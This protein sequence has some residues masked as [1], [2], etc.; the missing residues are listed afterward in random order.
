M[1]IARRLGCRVL[2][3]PYVPLGCAAHCVLSTRRRDVLCPS[4]RVCKGLAEPGPRGEWS[5]E[6]KW[7]SSWGLVLLLLILVSVLLI[8]TLINIRS[9]VTVVS[10]HP[11]RWCT[12]PLGVVPAG[13]GGRRWPL[14][15]R[16]PNFQKSVFLFPLYFIL[17]EHDVLFF[18]E[19]VYGSF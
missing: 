15:R 6:N 1:N 2:G 7:S 3:L 16:R 13:V 12:P 11:A 17:G 8:G 5:G 9:I 19:Y 18:Q 4:L 14:S 10:V